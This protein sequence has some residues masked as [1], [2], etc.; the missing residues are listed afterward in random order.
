MDCLLPSL[1]LQVQVDLLLQ[2]IPAGGK[3]ADKVMEGAGDRVAAEQVYEGSSSFL[4]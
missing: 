3:R 4:R 2:V 1:L